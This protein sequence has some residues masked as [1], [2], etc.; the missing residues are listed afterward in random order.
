VI[1]QPNLS[2]LDIFVMMYTML[3]VGPLNIP[4]ISI[5]LH[6]QSDIDVASAVV[7]GKGV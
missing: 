7:V 6:L 5:M 2:L 1:L 3:E 4:V